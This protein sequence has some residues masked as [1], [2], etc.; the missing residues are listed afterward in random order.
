MSGTRSDEPA[1]SGAK[2]ASAEPANPRAPVGWGVLGATSMV[3]RLAVLPALAAS[4]TARLVSVASQSCQAGNYDDFGATRTQASY[5]AVLEDPEVE[6]VYI[7]LPNSL[8]A[9][10]VS[11]AAAAGRHVLCEKPLATSRAEA[12]AMAAACEAAGVVLMEAYM[13]PFH[14]R[15]AALAEL[16]ASGRLGGLRFAHAA[17]TGVLSRPDDHRWQPGMGGGALADVGIYCLAP[18]LTAAG[19]TPRAVAAAAKLSPSG[20]DAS[21]SGWMDL[22]DGMAGAIECSFEAPERQRLEIVGTAAAA[23]IERAFTPGPT[24]TVIELR[25][26]DGSIERIVTAGAN[27]YLLMVEHFGDVVRGAT[28]MAR[29]PAWSSR[30][31]GVIDQLA[32]AAGLPRHDNHLRSPPGT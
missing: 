8:H 21:F 9:R 6:A 3:A 14:P 24:D 23:V 17:F 22:G 1:A 30:L 18:I 29:G 10:W 13:T 20:V 31:A 32:E 7:P 25:K 19:R 5:E 11:A 15:A 2:E 27:P 28:P 12:Q 16:V 4:H 26:R